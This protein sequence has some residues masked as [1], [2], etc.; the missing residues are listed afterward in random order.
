MHAAAAGQTH[1]D[2]CLPA[3]KCKETL[4]ELKVTAGCAAGANYGRQD[5]KKTSKK[6]TAISEKPRAKA[7]CGK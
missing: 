2:K 5:T 1:L 6:P 3:T 7:G 4:K